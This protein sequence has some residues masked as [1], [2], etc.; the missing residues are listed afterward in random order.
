MLLRSHAEALQLSVSIDT[1][2]LVQDGQQSTGC[3][4]ASQPP[5][6]EHCQ[7]TSCSKSRVLPIPPSRPPSSMAS[8]EMR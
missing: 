3:I 6:A 1:S 2:L 4:Y 7:Y 5:E 8:P